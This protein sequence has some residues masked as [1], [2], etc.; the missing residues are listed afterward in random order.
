MYLFIVILVYARIYAKI[1]KFGSEEW[2]EE[3]EIETKTWQK[4]QKYT[5]SGVI[6]KIEGFLLK[7]GILR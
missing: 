5:C 6:L 3:S 4:W 2:L 1:N 7:M